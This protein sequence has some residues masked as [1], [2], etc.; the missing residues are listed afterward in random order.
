L[1]RVPFQVK[2]APSA[3]PFPVIALPSID[4]VNWPFPPALISDQT[5]NSPV[6]PSAN[7]QSALSCVFEFL[8]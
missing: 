1:A 8:K 7:T 4:S 6:L 3:V 5:C 2:V